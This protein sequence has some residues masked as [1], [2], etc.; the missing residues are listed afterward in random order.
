MYLTVN[1]MLVDFPSLDGNCEFTH[2]IIA[3][4]TPSLEPSLAGGEWLA[5]LNVSGNRIHVTRGGGGGGIK[6]VSERTS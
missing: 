5:D 2:E 4:T 6:G 1:N 3:A